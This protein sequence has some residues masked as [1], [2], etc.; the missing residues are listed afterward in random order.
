MVKIAIAGGSGNVAQEI[1][2]VLLETKKHEII[3]M[4]RK[5]DSG[6]EAISGITWVQTDYKDPDQLA[7]ILQGVH[8]LLSFATEQ[9]DPNSPVQKR[10]IDAAV[11]AGVK[12]FAPS[13]WATS[14]LEHLGWYGYKGEI[15]RYL[16]ELNR[17]KKV[18]QYTLFQPG[19]FVNYLT[20][21]YKTTKH[22]HQ[23]EIP[24]DFANRR[25]ITIDGSDN[26]QITLTTVKDLANVVAR[27]IDFE[28]EWPVVGGIQGTN[29]SLG[30]LLAL[31]KT[32]RGGLPFLVERVKAEELKDGTW[33][34]S[35]VPIVD[36][37]SIPPDQLDVFSRIGV[38]G[39]LL[40]FSAKAFVVSDEWNQ[41]LPDYK[42]TQAEE[43]LASEWSGK[44]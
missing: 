38:A 15:R 26:D 20:R 12:R 1:I 39:I 4:S 22:I 5:R 30:Q 17:D 14:G 33:Q 35:W 13:E 27:A 6:A 8:T 44:P 43:F 34:T 7:Q 41:L 24:F 40:A 42:F 29:I 28:G 25:F 19:L 2:D 36:H 16:R 18:L 9:D 23:I 37:P 11:Q 10:L 3:I 21:P 32:V 31:G